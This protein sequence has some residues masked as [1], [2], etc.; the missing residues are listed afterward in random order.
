MGDSQN[1]ELNLLQATLRGFLDSVGTVLH[2][3]VLRQLLRR[4]GVKLGRQ[5]AEQYRLVNGTSSPFSRKD[6]ARCLLSLKDIWGWEC[7]MLEENANSLSL[8]IPSCPF[9]SSAAC[10]SE[11]CGLA[12]AAFGG[13]AAD[14]F[15]YAKVCL[16]RGC[17]TPPNNCLVTIHI[18]KT[19]ESLTAQGETYPEALEGTDR[20][21]AG[22]EEDT[23]PARL[24]RRECDVLKLIGAGMSDKEVA[25]ALSLSVRTAANH[26]ARIRSK[27]GV[28]GRSALIRFALRHRLAEL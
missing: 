1:A 9:G 25:A 11:L 27:L 12:S 19:D 26:A 17:G 13:I 20:P 14:Q 16:T 21:N 5:A 2:P 15:G 10:G 24:S 22:F 6:Y 28:L 8:Q 3:S 7:V 4:I 18:R 23:P